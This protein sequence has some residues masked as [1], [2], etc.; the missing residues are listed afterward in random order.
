MN[1]EKTL[2]DVKNL[3]K[4]FRSGAQTVKAVDG[5]SFSIKEGETLG[6]VGESGC[7]K[8]TIGRCILRLIDPNAGEI[9][10]TDRRIDDLSKKAMRPI[11]K[12]MQIIFQDPFASLDPRKTVLDI[13]AEA[14]RAHV[15]LTKDERRE[16]V[17]QL[18]DVVGMRPEHIHRYP[19]EFSG[20]QRQRIGIA[21]A[22]A[23]NPRL[24]VCDEPVSALDVSIQA[25]IM[26]L[27]KD[28]QR[29]WQLTYLFI[30]HDLRI[31]KH[32]CDRIAVMYL[33]VIVES[34]TKEQIYEH[35]KHPYTRALLSAIPKGDPDIP[36]SRIALEGDVPSPVDPP[37]GCRFRTRCPEAKA[38]C[39]E[40]VP[41]LVDLKNGHCCACHMRKREEDDV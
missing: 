40:T 35:A 28:L 36:P 17:L 37:S 1:K 24:V 12:Q 39:A 27:M 15:P 6:L 4:H 31:V 10:F 3:V 11:R 41:V 7:G 9:W 25:Q 19:H 13:V 2:L 16:K 33:G 5:V 29:E 14:Y 26:N 30:S 22:L 32:I 18:M 8:T 38:I 34:G 23:L 20:G 21:R